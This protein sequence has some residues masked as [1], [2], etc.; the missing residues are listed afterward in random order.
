MAGAT[1]RAFAHLRHHAADAPNDPELVVKDPDYPELSSPGPAPQENSYG[2]I[3]FSEDFKSIPNEQFQAMPGPSA[4]EIAPPPMSPDVHPDHKSLDADEVNV[5]KQLLQPAGDPPQQPQEPS[6]GEY[7]KLLDETFGDDD[8]DEVNAIQDLLKPAGQPPQ[9]KPAGQDDQPGQPEEHKKH[10]DQLNALSAMMYQY[11]HQYI[12]DDDYLAWEKSLTPEQVDHYLHHDQN[13]AYEDL[14]KFRNNKNPETGPPE[15]EWEQQLLP[16]KKPPHQPGSSWNDGSSKLMLPAG[17]TTWEAVGTGHKAVLQPGAAAFLESQGYDPES[18]KKLPWQGEKGGGWSKKSLAAAWESLPDSEKAY[19]QNHEQSGVAPGDE[20][21]PGSGPKAAAPPSSHL[22][23]QGQLT[24]EFKAWF[25]QNN[26]GADL[27]H[28]SNSGLVEMLTQ[29]PD[30]IWVQQKVKGFQSYQEQQKK[31]NENLADLAS[32]LIDGGLDI[33]DPHYTDWGFSLSPEQVEH[34]TQDPDQ[35]AQDYYSYLSAEQKAGKGA[36]TTP[37]AS[38]AGAT[39]DQI[40]GVSFGLVQK[41]PGGSGNYELKPGAAAF[42]ESQGYDLNKYLSDNSSEKW[43]LGSEFAYLPEDQKAIYAEQEQQKEQGQNLK[44]LLNTGNDFDPW[45]DAHNDGGD[46]HSVDT[47]TTPAG[48]Y[49]IQIFLDS[50]GYDD[51]GYY[52]K[53]KDHEGNLVAD[54]YGIDDPDYAYKKAKDE[55]YAHA[56]SVAGNDQSEINQIKQQQNTFTIDQLG[57]AVPTQ[58]QMMS[59]GLTA[60]QT[61]SWSSES[62]SYFKITYEDAKKDQQKMDHD[63][64]VDNWPS[65]SKIV[66]GIEGNN[67]QQNTPPVSSAEEQEI[68]ADLASLP[69]AEPVRPFKSQQAQDADVAA[70]SQVRPQSEVGRKNFS[71]FTT[72]WG[73]NVLSPEQEQGLYKSWFGKDVT[74]EQANAWFQ[75]IWEHHS[76]PSEGD[77]GRGSYKELIERA[78]KWDEKPWRPDSFVVKYK[79]ALPDLVKWYDDHPDVTSGIIRQHAPSRE[80]AKSELD[81]ALR[82]PDLM[83]WQRQRLED[84][85]E[86]YFMGSGLSKKDKDVL[87]STGFQNWWDKAPENYRDTVKNHPGF[88]IDDFQNFLNGGSTY[89]AVPEGHGRPVKYDFTQERFFP[90]IDPHSDSSDT[91]FDLNWPGWA[92]QHPFT[93]VNPQELYDSTTE[94]PPI[95]PGFTV[96]PPRHNEEKV[97]RRPEYAPQDPSQQE[98]MFGPGEEWVSPRK[99]VELHRG[100]GLDL[101]RYDHLV[102]PSENLKTHNPTK[103]KK[104]YAEYQKNLHRKWLADQIRARMFGSGARPDDVPDLFNTYEDKDAPPEVE[105]PEKWTQRGP[106]GMD[107][108]FDFNKWCQDNDVPPEQMYS[109]AKKWGVNDPGKYGTPPMSGGPWGKGMSGDYSWKSDPGFAHLVLDFAQATDYRGGGGYAPPGSIGDHWSLNKDTAKSFGG[110]GNSYLHLMVDADWDGRGGWKDDPFGV[111]GLD[112]NPHNEQELSMAPGAPMWVKR[113]RIHHN[114]GDGSDGSWNHHNWHDLRVEPHW[115]SASRA[116]AA[117]MNAAVNRIAAL[118]EAHEEIEAIKHL[119]TSDLEQRIAALENGGGKRALV[120]VDPQN[121]FVSGSLRVPGAQRAVRRLSKL[122]RNPAGYDH[123]VTTQDWHTDPGAHWSETPDMVDSWPEHGRADSWGAALH[124]D[125]A[126]APVSERFFKGQRGPGYSGFEGTTAAGQPLADWLRQAGVAQV[127]VAGL[128]TDHCVH[129]TASDAHGQGFHTRVLPHYSAAVSPEGE[130]RALADLASRGVEVV[131]GPNHIASRTA[132]RLRGAFIK[133]AKYPREWRAEAPY[134]RF[135]SGRARNRPPSVL[136]D[137]DDPNGEIIDPSEI[138]YEPDGTTVRAYHPNGEPLGKY[139]WQDDHYFGHPAHISVAQ[140]VPRYQGQGVSGAIIDYIREH[141]RPDLVHS[142]H[143][144]DGSLSYQGRAGALR[145]WGNTAE[146]HSDYFNTRPY[147]YGASEP[148]VFSYGPPTAAQRK[149]HNELK[150]EFIEDKNHPNWTGTRSSGPHD[151]NMH[152]EDGDRH[153]YGYDEDGDYVGLEDGGYDEN[154]YDEDGYDHNGYDENGYDSEGY[155]G[156]GIHGETGLN[157]E[158]RTR[159]GYTPG[160]GTPPEGTVPMTEMESHW[161]EHKFPIPS[162]EHLRMMEDASVGGTPTMYAVRHPSEVS[163]H[164]GEYHV[165]NGD[166]LYS[167]LDRA[168]QVAFHPD[169]PSLDKDIVSVRGLDSDHLHTDASGRTPEDFHYAPDSSSATSASGMQGKDAEYT[170]SALAELVH[171]PQRHQRILGDLGIGWRQGT[172]PSTDHPSFEYADQ[173]SG[174]TG[175]MAQH[176]TGQWI[177]R[178]YPQFGP[179]QLGRYER[180]PDAADAI[181]AGTRPGPT[182]EQHA[183]EANNDFPAT[184]GGVVSWEPHPNGQGLTARTPQGDLHVIQDPDSGRWNWHAGP[185]GFQPGDEVSVRDTTSHSSSPAAAAESIG[186]I[187][188]SPFHGGLADELGEGWRPHPRSL[189]AYSRRLPS[190]NHAFVSP[191]DDGGYRSGIQLDDGSGQPSRQLS[192]VRH[193]PDLAQAKAF[194]N[195]RESPIPASDLGGGWRDSDLGP[196]YFPSYIHEYQH[197]SGAAATVAWSNQGGWLPTV[198][199]TGEYYRGGTHETPQAAASWASSFMDGLGSK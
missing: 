91:E 143:R 16:T 126:D 195:H 35:A 48:Q 22:D 32:E 53:V 127:D 149:A 150:Q 29:N 140:V 14:E 96:N 71:S 154:G 2:P 43:N 160:D 153:D 20:G 148:E 69:P 38:W 159:H 23:A 198:H 6:H 93:R 77:R 87:N 138:R 58:E 152:D 173:N 15:D 112:D 196:R 136:R 169:D 42:L 167:S 122:M 60:D 175:Q 12:G 45:E 144:G 101:S 67:Q 97:V 4:E 128:A 165:G 28:P 186:R 119:A 26:T 137:P 18:F 146:E 170:S 47:V 65:M 92:G 74:P 124:P 63:E 64:W 57:K 94:K 34:Y 51:T 121:D 85:R 188:S 24:P 54:L 177:A 151:H 52:Y 90:R 172:L 156:G 193:S 191:H 104:E 134:G 73:N 25:A 78:H 139:I 55:A 99:P 189:S 89:S 79:D 183:L 133:E 39:Q 68:A 187:T 11:H 166:T 105:V 103:Y 111:Y 75:A 142:G 120:V 199:H 88:A 5:I 163:P 36:D 190:G 125:L 141:H 49:H 7:Q 66:M 118:E 61:E 84:L 62:P 72:W 40:Q 107:D 135:P 197:P 157:R 174:R 30:D 162:E 41:T 31:H 161:A 102:L 145:D 108:V 110:R 70:W 98:L 192:F 179:E 33:A 81:F 131:P 1:A 80:E 178:H 95:M 19:Y 180:Y 83:E 27:D 46:L 194:I 158:G 100:I 132:R 185:H 56:A 37:G 10:L 130:K 115:R 17:L 76:Q 116:P 171:D 129:A 109:L 44:D 184:A 21:D 182:M 176:S 117:A 123:V 50:D 9:P 113:V 155:D 164:S 106:Q 114:K 3:N 59:W 168:R 86:T 82:N 13:Q 8:D 147:N 181:R